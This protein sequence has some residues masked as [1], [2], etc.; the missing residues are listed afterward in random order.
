MLDLVNFAYMN[1]FLNKLNRK[2]KNEFVVSELFVCSDL[3][4]S[5]WKSQEL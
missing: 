2:G 5:C 3:L 1:S 4:Y